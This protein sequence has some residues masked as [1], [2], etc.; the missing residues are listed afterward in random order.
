MADRIFLQLD[1]FTA[2]ASDSR[3]WIVL[4]RGNK[5]GHFGPWNPKHFVATR[6]DVL[7]RCIK[8]LGCDT[9]ELE[10]ATQR[11]LQAIPDTFKQW[12]T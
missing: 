9:Q 8:D 12:R 5:K 11:V 4:R 1:D 10:M 3:Q 7:M 6:K 2:L